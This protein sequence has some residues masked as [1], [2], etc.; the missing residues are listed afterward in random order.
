MLERVDRLEEQLVALV[1]VLG[2]LAR[3]VGH[4]RAGDD[5]LVEDELVA[6]LGEQRARGLLHAHADHGLAELLELGDQGREVRVAGQ[7]G[8]GVDVVAREAHLHRVDRQADV[9]RVL[10]RVGAVGNLDQLDAQLVQGRDRVVEALP[11]TIGAFGDDAPLVDQA[12]EDT[13]H[14]GTGAGLLMAVALAPAGAQRQVLVVDEHRHRTLLCI[15]THS[16]KLISCAC[17][18]CPCPLR[19]RRKTHSSPRA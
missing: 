6:V 9:R 3:E 14:V 4:A 10:A 1:L 17:C 5:V 16:F 18:A 8:K 7:D 15:N 12:L 2:H 13:L 11:V 19:E